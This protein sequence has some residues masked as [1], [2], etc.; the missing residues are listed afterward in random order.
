MV[1]FGRN[2]VRITVPVIALCT[3][4]TFAQ[5][6][7]VLADTMTDL[8][9]VLTPEARMKIATILSESNALT[10]SRQF[11]G[12]GVVVD[13]V[14]ESLITGDHLRDYAD[15]QR[16]DLGRDDHRKHVLFVVWISPKGWAFQISYDPAFP[17]RSRLSRDEISR[18]VNEVQSRFRAKDPNGAVLVGTM[19][20]AADLSGVNFGAP[21]SVPHG[22]KLWTETLLSAVVFGLILA[23]VSVRHRRA[24]AAGQKAISVGNVLGVLYYATCLVFWGVF[25]SA[26]FRFG[27]EFNDV[28][29]SWI[30]DLPPPTVDPVL[31]FLI[32]AVF[33]IIGICLVPGIIGVGLYLIGIALALAFFFGLFVQ[34]LM[35]LGRVSITGAI[36]A[37]IIGV[38]PVVWLFRKY[39]VPIGRAFWRI[40]EPVYGI[41]F[42]W[43]LTPLLRR[44]KEKRMVDDLNKK[45]SEVEA[46]V[47]RLQREYPQ[48]VP[49]I[50]SGSLTYDTWLERVIER[51]HD[52][53]R[54]KSIAE[55]TRL[56]ELAKKYFTEYRAMLDA[57][58]EL[59]LADQ[60]AAIRRL[61][62]LKK[63]LAL[64]NDV[65]D[66]RNT[67]AIGNEIRDLDRETTILAKKHELEQLKRKMAGGQGGPY[68]EGMN[69]KRE[70]R[71][72]DIEDNLFEALEHPM[73]TEVEAK[74]LY[75][76]LR[77]KI[78]RHSD[79]SDT[80]KDDLQA[81][82]KQRF[83]HYFKT[84]SSTP[85]F[86]ED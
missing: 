64:Q 58:D 22:G 84:A 24:K 34:P 60:D 29:M 6:P 68:K 50:G 38:L 82:L 83:T 23:L 76:K 66:L 46:V 41:F 55:R 40:A 65:A 21:P 62:R 25:I 17:G 35:A 74:L 48:A 51:F 2:W 16:E 56:I 8:A 36:V 26:P 85:I 11:F 45:R 44:R 43:W 30:R 78:D 13:R 5:A 49:E 20:L 53:D 47:L 1:G 33:I 15:L 9:S 75:E 69:D 7:F 61:E 81:R 52:R 80:D 28:F 72:V 73:N 70:R 3:G 12:F 71:L 59:T 18:I 31:N 10:V 77:Q 27:R 63:Q 19:L 39:R 67:A 32:Y 54:Q 4:A 37:S 14:P 86:E 79:L 57:H 42:D